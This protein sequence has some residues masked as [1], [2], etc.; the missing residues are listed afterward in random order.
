MLR[1]EFF[2]VRFHLVEQMLAWTDDL[3]GLEIAWVPRFG[4]E[5]GFLLK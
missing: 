1:S 4:P 5:D 3:L 2:L